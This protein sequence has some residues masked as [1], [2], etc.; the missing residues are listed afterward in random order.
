VKILTL[1]HWTEVRDSFGL[2]RE[3]LEESEEEDDPIGRTGVSTN[4][5]P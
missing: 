4:L 2:I 5:D 3:M 1:H